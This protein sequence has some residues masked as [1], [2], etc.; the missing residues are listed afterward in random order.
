VK[1]LIEILLA[2][3][4]HPIVVILVWIDLAG[5]RDIGLFRKI[6]W[7]LVALVWGIGPML[8]VFLGD[9]NFW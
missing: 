6:L 7:G 5:R 4:L 3:F 8:Y 2:I 1:L 9:G